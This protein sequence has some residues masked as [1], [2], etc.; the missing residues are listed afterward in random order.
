M[1]ISDVAILFLLGMSISIEK[2]NKNF[3]KKTK[4][5]RFFRQH[6]FV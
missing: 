4:T 3:E 1:I 2:E 6:H 5:K